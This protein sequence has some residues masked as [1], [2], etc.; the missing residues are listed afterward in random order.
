MFS[1]IPVENRSRYLASRLCQPDRWTD[2]TA[3]Q[4]A[5]LYDSEITSALDSLI[6][7]RTVTIRRRP[8]DP[9]L[10]GSVASQSAL[11]DGW[12][13][14]LCPV[15]SR[16][17]SLLAHGTPRVSCATLAQK[18]QHFWQAKIDAERSSPHQLWRSID[19]CAAQSWSC[20][21][22]GA[23]RFHRYFDDKVASVRSATAGAPPPL[24]RP[25]SCVA[26]F[27]DSS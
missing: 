2:C 9:G 16:N 26:L 5:D 6:P 24:F 3:D 4:L 13:G 18:R 23:E 25:M 8:S 7:V 10:I 17:P 22:F 15:V 11:F 20:S 1:Y 27:Q 19:W 12:N 14:P 21:A